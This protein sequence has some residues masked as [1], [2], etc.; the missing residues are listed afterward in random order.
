LHSPTGN[1]QLG[2]QSRTVVN[3]IDDDYHL[4]NIH[5]E[6][7]LTV[8]EWNIV[9]RLTLQTTSDCDLRTVSQQ[10][11]FSTV[12]VREDDKSKFH[13]FHNLTAVGTTVGATEEI[14]TTQEDDVLSFQLPQLMTEK[15]G[16][17]KISLY[18]V[19]RGGILG[20]Y[21]SDLMMSSNMKVMERIDKVVNFTWSTG[22]GHNNLWSSIHWKG[23]I[24]NPGITEK[25]CLFQVKGDNVRLWI[26]QF[27]VLDE[28]SD[29]TSSTSPATPPISSFSAFH[30]L[31]GAVVGDGDYIHEISLHVR[32]IHMDSLD[33]FHDGRVSL[34]WNASGSMDIVDPSY[35][36]AKAS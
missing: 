10:S 13:T 35:L 23:F 8:L 17:Y 7:P 33:F 11:L 12:L 5:I 16:N 1:A 26:D 15:I 9:P 29:T 6:C 14:V 19:F 31:S 24:R 28:W 21:Y 3:I 27:L 25:C 36:Y 18:Q 30:D 4:C 32:Q 22:G 34:S 20:T 2:T